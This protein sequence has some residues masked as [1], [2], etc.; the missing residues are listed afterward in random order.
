MRF[1][2]LKGRK[3]VSVNNAETEGQ[4][5]DAFLDLN[6]QTVAGLKVN[7][8]GLFSGHTDLPWDAIQSIGQSA[9][10]IEDPSALEQPNEAHGL[11]NL[12]T[13]TEIDGDKVLDNSGNH[14]GTVGD[15]EFDAASGQIIGYILSEG[16]LNQL[17]GQTR[18]VPASSVTSVGQKMIVVSTGA[19]QQ[20]N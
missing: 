7:M 12:P 11:D 18:M 13:A 1:S 2:D 14:V 5:E 3:V 6:A 8:S 10:T 15:L 17:Q 20:I 19:V 16:L 9:V 4:V